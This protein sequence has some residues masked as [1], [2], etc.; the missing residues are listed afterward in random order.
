M[1]QKLF[2]PE[3]IAQMNMRVR[4]GG[5]VLTLDWP[6]RR[7][8]VGCLLALTTPIVVVFLLLSPPSSE[9]HFAKIEALQLATP[10]DDVLLMQQQ[11]SAARK[12]SA[13]L[14]SPQPLRHLAIKTKAPSDADDS[15]IRMVMDTA[16]DR[17]AEILDDHWKLVGRQKRAPDSRYNINVTHSDLLSPDRPIPDTRPRGCARFKYDIRHL[18]T[19]T[20]VVPFYNEALSM[21]LRTVHSLLNRSPDQLLEEVR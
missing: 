14:K 4:F 11:R 9:D 18:P 15:V 19:V 10:I 6:S 8:F 17:R 2:D 12:D 21:I 3:A 7:S 13:T 16:A 20:V 1:F 5:A